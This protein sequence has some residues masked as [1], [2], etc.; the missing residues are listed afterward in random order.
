[1][2][3]VLNQTNPH[4]Q[5]HFYRLP[6]E[7]ILHVLD[8]VDTLD[9]PALICAVFGLLR[10]HNIAPNVSAHEATV[11]RRVSL[12]ISGGPE[13]RG[14]SAVSSPGLQRLPPELVVQINRHLTTGERVNFA[15]ATWPMI[16]V[17]RGW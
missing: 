1:M 5:C 11:M 12:S 9:L 2:N 14:R 15:V 3:G 16:D 17:E 7:L 4:I 8:Q 10:H 6:A 13:M